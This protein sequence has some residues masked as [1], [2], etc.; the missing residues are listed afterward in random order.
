MYVR[1]TSKHDS[2]K[3]GKPSIMKSGW[4]DRKTAGF[5]DSRKARRM[6]G[7]LASQPV[8]RLA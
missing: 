4:K 3:S 2:Q 7:L 5:H 8:S 1:I 6:D